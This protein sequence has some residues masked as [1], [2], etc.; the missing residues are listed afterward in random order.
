MSDSLF[1]GGF[2]LLIAGFLALDLGVFNK[3]SHTVSVREALIFTA[4]WVSLALGFFLFLRYFGH[5][6]H[7]IETMDDLQAI[8]ERHRHGLNFDLG[9]GFLSNLQM[10]RKQL[11]LEFIT[12]YVIE[13]A[14][15]IDNIF[16]ILMIF[17]SFGVDKKY[18]HRVLFWGIIGAV[19]MRFIFIFSLSALIHEFE[20]ILA[21]FG[22]ILIFSAV[23]MFLNRNE[24]DKIDVQEHKLVKFV[25]RHFPVTPSYAGQKFFTK[26]DGK[27]YLTPL[28][29]VLIIIEF[30]DVIFAVDSVPAI[31]SVTQDSY[32]VFFSNIFAIIGL[33]SLFFL[34]SSIVGMFRFLKTGL[35]I[36]LVFVGVKMLLEVLFHI[37]IGT[38]ASLLFIL[39][40]L[41]L[42]I[43]L[44]AVIP[45]KKEKQA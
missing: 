27:Q 21:I 18:Y 15:S 44:S 24:E 9:A 19:M 20:W 8:N 13:Y 42:C 33:R 4:I 30:S 23:K 25:S 38:K 40:T 10:Y 31:F 37:S 17:M 41:V 36:L 1:L 11:S 3:N 29:L 22:V 16:V 12:G 5:W 14:L 28:F 7:G 39:A 32:I 26:V 35:S 43:G 45:E 6:I 34:L 2:I